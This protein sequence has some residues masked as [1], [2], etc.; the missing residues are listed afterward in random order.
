MRPVKLAPGCKGSLLALFAVFLWSG[1]FIIARGM[2]E[3]IPPVT[4]AMLRWSCATLLVLPLGW[5]HIKHDWPVIRKHW[6]YYLVIALSSVTGFNTLIYIAGHS[7]QAVNLSLISTGG[8]PLFMLIMGHIFWKEPV[9]L[10]Q[11]IG[12]GTAFVGVFLLLTGG[13][14]EVLRSLRFAEG[15]LWMLGATF[16]FALYSLLML[17]RP[18]PTS[19][20][21]VF[22][23]TFAVGLV[24]L[25][26][27]WLLEI[28]LNPSFTAPSPAV[29]LRSWLPMALYL[30]GLAS[31][32]AFFCWNKAIECIGAAKAGALYFTLPAFCGAEA[33]LL[34]GEPL[35]LAHFFSAA[36]IILGVWLSTRR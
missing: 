17:R 36:F 27:L 25:F 35:L 15:D 30:G 34:L 3:V 20:L 7:T 11:L 21:G 31:L 5:R 10:R 24:C 32:A 4:L 1:N 28:H 8:T 18:G 22:S 2:A 13:D 6:R 9:Y 26:P 12:M 19:Q 29:F 33:L 23:I 16:L 14:I